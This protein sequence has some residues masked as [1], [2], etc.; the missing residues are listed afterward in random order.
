MREASSHVYTHTKEGYAKN[1]TFSYMSTTYY[2]IQPP[3]GCD[4]ERVDATIE[5]TLELIN[6]FSVSQP[7]GE[8]INSTRQVYEHL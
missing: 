1:N 2:N 3:T 4:F 8:I 5:K 6:S 7:R